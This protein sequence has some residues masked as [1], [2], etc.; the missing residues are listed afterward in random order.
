V[1]GRA[2]FPPRVVGPVVEDTGAAVDEVVV[3]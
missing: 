1:N 2:T 3:P